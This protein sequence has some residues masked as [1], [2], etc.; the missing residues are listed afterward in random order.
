MDG[1]SRAVTDRAS[2]PD[3]ASPV[4]SLPT[5]YLAAVSLS[6]P[7]VAFSPLG[8]FLEPEATSLNRSSLAQLDQEESGQKS[9]V[10]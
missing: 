5:A 4:K 3:V 8:T 9:L 6:A 10:A 1:E 7:E 2:H